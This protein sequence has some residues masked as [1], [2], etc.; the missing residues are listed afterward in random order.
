MNVQQDVS[1]QRASRVRPFFRGCAVG[2]L[3]IVLLMAL[4][5]FGAYRAL[6]GRYPSLTERLRD[7]G[8]EVVRGQFLDIAEP[9]SARTVFL[10]Q[11]VRILAGSRR[12]IAIL[13]QTAEI[14]GTVEGNVY[15][16]GQEITI[17]ADAEL[18]HHLHVTADRVIKKG[19]IEGEV[20]GYYRELKAA[21]EE[22]SKNSARQD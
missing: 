2:C 22:D 20:R 7:Q 16:W 6:R 13:A 4:G 15:F 5:M 1:H 18:K 14:H 19:R 11:H 17:A 8:Y 3:T 9:V 12:G 21:G 10:G